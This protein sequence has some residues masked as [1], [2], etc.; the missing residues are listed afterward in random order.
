MFAKV[1]EHL[2]VRFQYETTAAE[3]ALPGDA[4][5]ASRLASLAPDL[6]HPLAQ[7][8]QRGDDEE[9]KAAAE[10]IRAHDAPLA[11]AL[12]RALDQC[13]LDELVSLLEQAAR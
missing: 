9:A 5:T 1:A 13:R 10:Q 7:A 3:E 6:R 11:D 4:L 12:K 2:G 8:L